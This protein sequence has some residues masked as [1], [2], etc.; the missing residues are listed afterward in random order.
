[1]K[2]GGRDRQ[3][4]T[5]DLIEVVATTFENFFSTRKRRLIA[6]SKIIGLPL[7][8][9]AALTGAVPESAAEDANAIAQFVDQNRSALAVGASD[10]ARRAQ[11]RIEQFKFYGVPNGTNVSFGI[12]IIDKLP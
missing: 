11:S 3:M 2:L 7:I 10:I 1:M 5:V 6:A 9:Y 12:S 4:M 8:A